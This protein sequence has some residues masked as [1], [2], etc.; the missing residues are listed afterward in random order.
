MRRSHTITA[1][2]AIIVMRIS[3]TKGLGLFTNNH[4][5]NNT[6]ATA[7]NV[8]KIIGTNARARL[9]K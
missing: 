7:T 9:G 6:S 3:D 4:T 8:N 5:T 1:I 2:I